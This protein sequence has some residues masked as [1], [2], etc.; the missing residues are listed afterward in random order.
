MENY[1]LVLG[2]PPNASQEQIKERFRF[3]AHAYHPDKFATPAHKKH[4]EEAFKKINDAY[5]ILSNPVRRAEYDRRQSSSDARYAEERR[6]GEEAEAARRRAE[7]ERR[8]REEAEAARHRAQERAQETWR[9][10][11]EAEAPYQE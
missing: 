2:V 11:E 6:R 9:Y 5:Q 10:A 3:L 4:A 7:E 8:K 1:Y